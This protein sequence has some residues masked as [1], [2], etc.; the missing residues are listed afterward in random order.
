MTRRYGIR[1]A[2][3]NGTG[4]AEAAGRHVL[5]DNPST[6]AEGRPVNESD[7]YVTPP[8]DLNPLDNEFGFTLDACAEPTTA[9][10]PRFCT[11]AGDGLKHSWA[12]EAAWLKPPY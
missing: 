7:R 9:K 3:V 2:A 8:E 6:C 12:G 11:S 4:G 1:P 5:T 10:C